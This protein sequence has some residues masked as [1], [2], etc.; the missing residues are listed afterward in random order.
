MN[1]II[2]IDEQSSYMKERELSKIET[3]VSSL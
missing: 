1:K 2:I 3:G